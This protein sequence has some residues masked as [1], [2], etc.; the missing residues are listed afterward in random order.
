MAGGTG[1]VLEE[2]RRLHLNEFR[3]D[4]SPGVRRATEGVALTEYAAAPPPTLLEQLRVYTFGAWG[5]VDRLALTAGGDDGLRAALKLYRKSHN[6]VVCGTP[7]YARFAQLASNDD[8]IWVG[9]RLGL[10]TTRHEFPRLLAPYDGLLK[11]GAVVYIGNP[12]NPTGGIWSR[13]DVEV[14]AKKYMASV[15]IVDEAYIE[16]ASMGIA[17]GEGTDHDARESLSNASLAPITLSLANVVVVRTFSHAF[18]LAATRIGYLVAHPDTIAGLKRF[19][20]AGATT[21][22]GR[23]AAGACLGE[24]PHYARATRLAVVERRRLARGLLDDGWHVIDTEGNFLLA[25]VGAAARFAAAAR[26]RGVAVR[27][28]LD[29]QG[30]VRVTAG[31]PA[32]TDAALAA[33]A[34]AKKVRPGVDPLQLYDT[35]KVLIAGLTVMLHRLSEA[36]A[37]IPALGLVCW[38]ESGSLLGAV[39]HG[40]IVPWDT[41]INIGYATGAEDLVDTPAFDGAME[42]AGL[43]RAWDR[44]GHRWR[45]SDAAGGSAR[46]D[47]LPY[48]MEADG[49]YRA[50]GAPPAGPKCT[51]SY[52]PEEL[53]PLRLA[54]F[55]VMQWAI[56]ARA[57]L[58]LARALG[59]DFMTSAVIGDRPGF[60]VSPGGSVVRML[61]SD[62]CAP[63]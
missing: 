35:P 17:E 37:R 12:N 19:L 33:F 28:L 22:V 10:N 9:Y 5:G 45:I 47:L 41:N 58:V 40:G 16:F 6:I 7:G 26:A 63:A 61:G 49:H 56:P 44:A 31:T 24:L 57:E 25:Y 38:L 54:T 23:R 53:F 55:G 4:H 27:P 39:R 52:L 43:R 2:P 13:E 34:A 21:D 36:V 11:A 46:V 15:F 50:G 42:T 1:V 18:G 30:F 29:P 62:D 32:D 51:T 48:R 60:P 59:A 8:Y 3:Y 14:L 20:D